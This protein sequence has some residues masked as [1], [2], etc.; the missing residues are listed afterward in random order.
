MLS[1][2]DI[3]FP[4]IRPNKV[5]I[6]LDFPQETLPSVAG[7]PVG[8]EMC[9]D[10]AYIQTVDLAN[11]KRAL[12][13]QFK[14]EI[15]GLFG[16]KGDGWSYFAI[17]LEQDGT[18]YAKKATG[19]SP[20]TDGNRTYSIENPNWK[21]GESE[22]VTEIL[23]EVVAAWETDQRLNNPVVVDKSPIYQLALWLEQNKEKAAQ[24]IPASLLTSANH[25]FYSNN[26]ILANGG[27][28]LSVDVDDNRQAGFPPSLGVVNV[29]Q[30]TSNDRVVIKRIRGAL[31]LSL[32][33]YSEVDYPELGAKTKGDAPSTEIDPPAPRTIYLTPKGLCAVETE[34]GPCLKTTTPPDRLALIVAGALV[35]LG[36][37]MPSS[38]SLGS[39]IYYQA[40]QQVHSEGSPLPEA[41]TFEPGHKLEKALETLSESVNVPYANP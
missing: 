22:R 5:R 15:S 4:L 24:E 32:H 19:P 11:G 33:F 36:N 14:S 7:C 13:V 21:G 31:A 38:I 41:Y 8:K 27:E 3:Q 25:Y 37:E 2:G 1:G 17:Y 10:D 26:P 9:D 28:E 34:G 18:L 20:K 40:K 35:A 39:E 30:D 29:A 23:A 12:R 16:R 6:D